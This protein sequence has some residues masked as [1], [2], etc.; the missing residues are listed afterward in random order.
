MKDNRLLEI[1]KLLYADGTSSVQDIATAVGAS[2]ATVRR[3]LIMLESEGMISRTRGGAKIANSSGQEVAFTLREEQ[4]LAEKRAIS[5]LAYARLR[6]GSSILMDAGTTVLQLARCIRLR[7]M[8]LSVFTNCIPVAQIL[9]DVPDVKVTL[10]GGVLR[11]ENASMVGTLIERMLDELWFDQLFLGA[12][13]LADDCS[14]YTL[15]EA[16]ARLNARMIMRSSERM[17]LIDSTKFGHYLTYRVSPLR[18]TLSVITD[19]GL[20]REWQDRLADFKIDFALAPL[21]AD[22]QGEG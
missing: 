15:D 17:L 19:S 3:D 8:P 22:H 1:R 10:L 2:V 7:P 14:I 4:M 20:P 21:L 12:G 5:D 13:A 6:P 11:S 16:E 9:M 18:D